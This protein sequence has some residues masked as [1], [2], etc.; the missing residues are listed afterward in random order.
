VFAFPFCCCH[1]RFFLLGTQLSEGVTSYVFGS[2]SSPPVPLSMPPFD[3]TI[4]LKAHQTVNLFRLCSLLLSVR[5]TAFA[6]LHQIISLLF[7]EE[8]TVCADFFHPILSDSIFPSF[9]DP[10]VLL[11]GRAVSLVFIFPVPFFFSP[12]KPVHGTPF[13]WF[14]P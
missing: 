11:P 5:S 12:F 13:H 10:L 6:F 14:P 9:L 7:L 2:A 4:F 1:R 3:W 8:L